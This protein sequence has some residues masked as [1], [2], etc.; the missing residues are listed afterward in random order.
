MPGRQPTTLRS[1]A[2]RLAAL[3]AVPLAAAGML[4]GT[5]QAAHA[6][7]AAAS[8]TDDF[9]GAAGSGVDGSKWRF[10]DRKSVV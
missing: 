3:A 2:A 7:P 6:A 1:R 10:E 5:G 9:D 4:F 8:F